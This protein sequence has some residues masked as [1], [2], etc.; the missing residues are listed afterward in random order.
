MRNKYDVKP[1]LKR[2]ARPEAWIMGPDPYTRELYYAWAKHRSQALFRHEQYLLTWEDWQ[3]IWHNRDDFLARGRSSND[4]C[5]A[6]FDDQ[7]PWSMDNVA[8]MTRRQHLQ[9]NQSRNRLLQHHS[10]L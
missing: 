9:M 7:G 8:V 4:L 1:A 10:Q 3:Q 6:R 5:L 2:R